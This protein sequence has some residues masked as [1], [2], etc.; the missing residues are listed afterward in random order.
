MKYNW[1]FAVSLVGL[2]CPVLLAPVRGQENNRPPEGFTSLFNGRD[3]Q[4]WTGNTTRDPREIAALSP[5]ERA[6]WD[7]TM[8]QGISEHWRVDDG[9]LVSDGQEPYLATTSVYGNFELWVDWKISPAG[10]SGI[11]LRGVPQV[12]IWDPANPAELHN[13]AD[14]GSGGLWN[15]QKNARFPTEFADRPIGQWNRMFIRMVGPYVSVR[16]NDKE[17]VDNVVLEN[18]YDRSIPV[19]ERGPIYLQTHGSESRFKNIFIR[20]IPDDEAKHVLAN[21]GDGQK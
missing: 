7:A 18:F 4:N 12:Q 3:I 8:K 19:F 2:L 13:G 9:D 11:Y 21:I 15:N 20:E 14:K 5:S 10:D 6:T 16:L 17:V 1:C